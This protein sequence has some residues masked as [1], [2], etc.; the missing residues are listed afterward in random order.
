[1]HHGLDLVLARPF[2]QDGWHILNFTVVFILLLGF[3]INEL[4][5]I[6]ITYTLR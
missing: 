1:M 3:F 4:N 5:S 2:L 6:C